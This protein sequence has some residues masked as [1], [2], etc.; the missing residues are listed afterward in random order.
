VFFA[1]SLEVL[2]IDGRV[3]AIDP[4]TGDRHHLKHLGITEL[5]SLDLFRL[6]IQAAGASDLVDVIVSTSHEA[7]VG[8]SEPIDFLFIDGWHSYD[9]VMTDGH[10]W[11]PHLTD[12]AVV[13][14]DDV[15]STNE[16][17]RAVSDLTTNTR[18]HLYGEVFGQAFAGIPSDPPE[19]V[20]TVL[21]ARHP[22]T[23]HFPGHNPAG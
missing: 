6:H 21:K 11:I 19:A 20:R 16:V 13:V 5:P 7:S 8:W 17:A 18:I 12:R 22:L 1:K 10:D 23:R 15:S 14:F 2:G 9:A 3:T 4:H